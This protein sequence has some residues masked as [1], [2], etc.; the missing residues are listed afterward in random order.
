MKQN[1][2]HIERVIRI[3]AGIGLL[4]FVFVGPKTMWGLVGIIPL[5]TGVMCW[6]P[7]YA[8]LGISTCKASE[9]ESA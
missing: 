1:V 6:C 9:K 3:L 4:A 5:I 8:L 7:S 2:H